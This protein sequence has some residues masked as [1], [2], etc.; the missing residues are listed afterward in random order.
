MNSVVISDTSCIIAFNRI[1]RLEILHAVF[2]IIITTKEVQEEYGKPFPL[3]ISVK[4]V[5]DLNKKYELEKVLDKGE[6]SAIALAV[7]TKDSLL[8]IDEKKGRN[9]AK[10]NHLNIIG[11]LKILLLAKQKGVINS[12]AEIITLMEQN[13]FR[14]SKNIKESLLKE[15]E[16]L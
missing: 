7:E 1:G 15:A 6:A 9:I 3:W 8:I 11:T 2:P 12:V 5:K 4:E 10:E 16:E 14:F 13:H